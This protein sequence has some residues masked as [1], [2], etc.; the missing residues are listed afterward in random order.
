MK[1]VLVLVAML[2]IAMTGAIAGTTASAKTAETSASE[3][4]GLRATISPAR[5]TRYQ[6][7][8]STLT[9]ARPRTSYYCAMTV[10]K[11]GV[12]A[13]ASLAYTAGF[14]QTKTNASGRATCRQTFVPFKG[15]YKGQR[16]SCPPTRADKRAGWRC[17]I[18]WSNSNRLSEHT[19]AYFGF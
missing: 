6:A 11:P 14:V 15:T 13:S 9:G 5:P 12:P 19:V 16:H 17:G 3:R 2:G 8:S 4:A 10:Y 18:G 7:V 1:K